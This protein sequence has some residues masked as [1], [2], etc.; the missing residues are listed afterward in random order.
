MSALHSLQGALL[1]DLRKGSLRKMGL[2]TAMAPE[3]A[4]P[5]RRK[6]PALQTPLEIWTDTPSAS[7][8]DAVL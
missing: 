4:A 6:L 1:E 8:K 2:L 5:L 7:K 3:L